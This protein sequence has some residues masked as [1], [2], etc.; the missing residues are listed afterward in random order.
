LD[1]SLSPRNATCS[2]RCGIRSNTPG[3]LAETP[4][5]RSRH[6]CAIVVPYLSAIAGG[7]I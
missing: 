4:P 3:P 2:D 7:M 6:P 1:N 5:V